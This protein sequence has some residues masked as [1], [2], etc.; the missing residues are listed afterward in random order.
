[1]HIIYTSYEKNDLDL[2]AKEYEEN[3]YKLLEKTKYNG[4]YK[5]MVY[6]GMDDLGKSFRLDENQFN[7]LIPKVNPYRVSRK[8]EEV[9]LPDYDYI[10]GGWMNVYTLPQISYVLKDDNSIIFNSPSKKYNYY[11]SDEKSIFVLNPFYSIYDLAF[12]YFGKKDFPKIESVAN[13]RVIIDYYKTYIER[14]VENVEKVDSDNFE[15][16]DGEHQHFYHSNMLKQDFI[17][18]INSYKNLSYNSATF[19]FKNIVK[20]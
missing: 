18:N 4:L 1:M 16:F 7:K 14:I 20:K 6:K 19:I 10:V 15:R 12:F 13:Y 11:S 9:Y 8:I 5:I 2:L 17:K 3:D